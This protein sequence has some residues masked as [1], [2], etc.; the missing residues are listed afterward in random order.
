MRSQDIRYKNPDNDPRGPYVLTD[1]TAPYDRPLL[2]YE[3][4]GKLPPEGRSWR[5]SKQKAEELERD[6][7]VIFSSSGLPK[8]KRYLCDG[9]DTLRQILLSLPDEKVEHEID[10]TRKIVPRLAEILNYD[11][12]ETFYEYGRDQYRAD[13]ILASSVEAKPWVVLEIKNRLKPENITDWVYQIRRYLD[14]FD[15]HTGVVISSEILILVS[16]NEVKHFSLR[17]LSL[18]QAEE[19]LLTLERGAHRSSLRKAP[20]HGPLVDLIEAVEK[21]VTNEEK[22]KSLETVARFLINSVPSLS[23]KY[24]NLQTRSS[25]IDVV[26]EYNR[27]HGVIPL[28]NE[29]GRYS[30]V[31]CKNWSRPVGASQVRDFLGKIHKCK[32][33]IGI[34]FSKNGVTGIDSGADALREIQN[35]FD[36]HGVFVLVFSLEDLRTIKDGSAFLKALDRKADNLRFDS[37]G[38]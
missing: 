32:V 20:M 36:C 3:W 38:C 30:L 27:S 25:E 8:L 22:G 15:C 29:L 10:L 34:I 1:V 6:G 18:E 4:H 11:E 35:Q 2:R 7:R 26:I 12:E 21:S 24:S 23:C 19:I 9:R 16:G 5:F 28:F 37:Q 31:E 13:V 17:T 33:K 14:A